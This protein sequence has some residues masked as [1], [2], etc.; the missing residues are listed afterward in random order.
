MSASKG[1]PDW[2][3]DPT[4]VRSVVLRSGEDAR[5][6]Q[7]KVK[8]FSDHLGSAAESAGSLSSGGEVP[9]MGLVGAALAQFAQ[10]CEKKIKF[11]AA[12][13]GRSVDG[14]VKATAEYLEGDLQMAAQAQRE[15]LKAPE[16]DA[17]P[18][19]RRDASK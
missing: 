7:E 14:A 4:G 17:K 15:A 11:I 13:A 16:T 8:T 5:A 3:I 2:D 10:T 1:K 18:R 9:E 12:R 19:G 6:F